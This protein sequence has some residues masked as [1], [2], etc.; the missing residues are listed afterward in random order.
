[1]DNLLIHRQKV[2]DNSLI[3]RFIHRNC[4]QETVI[5]RSYPQTNFIHR[6]LS[7]EK[8]ST[9]SQKSKSGDKIIH[10]SLIHK[11]LST[12][13]T[14]PQASATYLSTAHTFVHK[15]HD[16]STGEQQHLSTE[17]TTN[18]KVIHIF[19][20]P[21]DYFIHKQYLSTT[22]PKRQIKN[23]S[24]YSHFGD[25]FLSTYPQFS[26]ICPLI[27][28]TKS[29]FLNYPQLL[30][31]ITLSTAPLSTAPSLST[32]L[33]YPQV[34]LIHNRQ[35]IHRRNLSTTRATYPQAKEVKNFLIFFKK[36]IY[37][38]LKR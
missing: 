7:T 16:L 15:S 29:N 17:H 5:H 12:T 6:Y 3:H 11:Q 18:K 13:P 14:Y 28:R 31:G 37:K 23:L 34:R 35:V 21:Q 1:V 19:T 33:T 24:T 30:L 4:P 20:Y 22:S 32:S 25:N 8:L 2:G 10:S 27:H 36:S 38:K 9:A 26:F